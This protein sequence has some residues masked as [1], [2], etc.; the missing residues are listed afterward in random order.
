[1]EI[2]QPQSAALNG[3]DGL[4][5]DAYRVTDVDAQPHPLVAILDCPQCIGRRRIPFVPRSVVVNGQTNVELLDHRLDAIEQLGI[6]AGHD[7]RHAGVLG[8]FENFANLIRLAKRDHAAAESVIPA[9]STLSCAARHS[10]AVLASGRCMSFK[11]M[12]FSPSSR[13]MAS[14]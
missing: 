10:A 7:R 12:Y 1:M 3:C 9:A 14:A 11:Q 8:I 2:V 4:F 6:G 13:I 5:A